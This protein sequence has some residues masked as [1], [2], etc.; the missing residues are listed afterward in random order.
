M[1]DEE[2]AFLGP[3]GFDLGAFIANLVFALIRHHCLG[4]KEAKEL[5]QKCIPI[6]IDCYCSQCGTDISDSAEFVGNACGF[7]G[8]ELIRRSVV[9]SSFARPLT[10][11]CRT[12]G[13]AHVEDVS[14]IPEGELM[15]VQLGHALMIAN[16]STASQG[17]TGLVDILSASMKEKQ[18]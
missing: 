11:S 6:A 18:L 9:T 16:C 2:F 3:S 15:A 13:T 14:S 4:N 12:I 7:I 8:V 1:I 10:F 5:L 17:K